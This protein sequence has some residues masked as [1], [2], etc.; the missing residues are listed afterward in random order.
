MN[1][2]TAIALGA[3]LLLGCTQSS[4][5]T[6][7]AKEELPSPSTL[8]WGTL[9]YDKVHEFRLPDG[10]VCVVIPGRQIYYYGGVDPIVCDFSKRRE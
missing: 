8:F 7:P 6:G 1:K 9:G 2:L 4:T 3:S 5:A 10:T